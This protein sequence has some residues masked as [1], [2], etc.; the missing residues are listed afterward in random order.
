MSHA[1][2]VSLVADL[3]RSHLDNLDVIWLLQGTTYRRLFATILE[4]DKET[5]DINDIEQEDSLAHVDV[6]VDDDDEDAGEEFISISQRREERILDVRNKARHFFD[7]AVMTYE[8]ALQG[9]LGLGNERNKGNP[10]YIQHGKLL[11]ALNCFICLMC[12]MILF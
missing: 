10:R 8:E 5:S 7:K 1:G 4:E 9:I 2:G 11:V 6:V 12:F 3:R